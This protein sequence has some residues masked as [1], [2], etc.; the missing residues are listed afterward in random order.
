MSD[1]SE[2][3]LR[4]IETQDQ[5]GEERTAEEKPEDARLGTLARLIP[6]FKHLDEAG[7]RAAR[8]D[9]EDRGGGRHGDGVGVRPQAGRR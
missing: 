5:T 8:G 3:V 9:P 1:A 6:L 7:R 4:V 2:S